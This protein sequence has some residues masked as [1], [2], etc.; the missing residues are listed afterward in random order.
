MT[1]ETQREHPYDDTAETTAGNAGSRA[2]R[3]GAPAR[4]RAGDRAP[5]PRTSAPTATPRQEP[6]AAPAPGAG[7]R[8]GEAPG[9]PGPC[10]CT[11]P[12]EH[13]HLGADV[14]TGLCD[15]I[16]AALDAH[17]EVLR[18]RRAPD[19]PARGRRVPRLRKSLRHIER[20]TCDAATRDALLAHLPAA[21]DD[22]VLLRY[23][24]LALWTTW[25]DR[26]TG[27]RVIG[28]PE[29]E[30]I[31][32]KPFGGSYWGQDVI[33][34]IEDRLPAF[35][36]REYE[37]GGRCRLIETDGLPEALHAAVRADL[38]LGVEDF[39]RR[40]GALSGR[41]H[42][43]N[44]ATRLRDETLAA[45]NAMTAPSPTSRWIQR[46][47]NNRPPNVSS[48]VLRQVE[49]ARA[50]VEQMEIAVDLRRQPGETAEAMDAR[51]IEVRDAVR[52]AYLASLRAIEE[53][54]QPFYQFSGRGRT[55][56]VFGHNPGALTLPADVR[57]ILYRGFL[58]VDLKSAHL[59]LAAA[60]WDVDDVLETLKR[61][62]YSVW[63]DLLGHLGLGHLTP[64]TAD[65]AEAKDAL[66]RATYSVIYGMRESS[67]VW[68]FS[69]AA[70]RLVGPGAGTRLADHWLI[71]RLLDARDEHLAALTDGTVLET[72]TGIRVVVGGDVDAKSAMAT[73]AQAYEQQLMSVVLEYE[74]D[75][76]ETANP[77]SFHV[78]LWIHDGCYVAI[79]RSERKHVR[80]ISDRLARRAEELGVYARFEVETLG[81]PTDRAEAP[82]R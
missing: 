61:E 65:Y 3:T 38:S 80:E 33:A 40:V 20:L 79:S 37:L 66:K 22:P 32:G 64:G 60:L 18:R 43:K 75:H 74:R 25:L 77:P 82:G 73:L 53:Q 2:A 62:D 55:D 57:R 7:H 41:P 48:R 8:G 46:A 13:E 30:W 9:R 6:T 17:H 70:H 34:L 12:G 27:L 44:E 11:P 69:R 5:A 67:V 68:T 24:V 15:A 36:W 21:A 47:L 31:G 71:R 49:E 16:E 58:S 35:T 28:Q 39:E 78:A 76:H 14:E 59:Y 42:D 4:A 51:T 1:E 54:H 26:E 52:K 50:Y 63:T 10:P 29:L 81:G 45:C 72:P 23:T 56:R 19:K